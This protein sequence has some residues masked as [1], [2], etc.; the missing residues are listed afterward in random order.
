MSY[1]ESQINELTVKFAEKCANLGKPLRYGIVYDDGRD[2]KPGTMK[3]GWEALEY[4][5]TYIE[6][7]DRDD[8]SL[9]DVVSMAFGAYLM[10]L[11]V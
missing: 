10:R 8:I 7:I 6:S 11:S 9:D 5:A 2:P 3:I 1:N 4:V